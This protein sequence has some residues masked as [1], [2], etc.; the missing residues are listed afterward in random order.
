[1]WAGFP[2]FHGDGGWPTLVAAEIF[3][4]VILVSDENRWYDDKDAR[5]I[6]VEKLVGLQHNISCN[7]FMVSWSTC[8]ILL[9]ALLQHR[10]PEKWEGIGVAKLF[11]KK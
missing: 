3:S 1:M 6:D 10:T 5:A 8:L 11:R 2:W 4:T 7:S 9:Q